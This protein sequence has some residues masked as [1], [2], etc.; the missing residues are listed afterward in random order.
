[1]T[2]RDT[3]YITYI[4]IHC[5]FL[6]IPIGHIYLEPNTTIYYVFSSRITKRSR[7]NKYRLCSV[8]NIFLSF[9]NRKFYSWYNF[10]IVEII[11]TIDRTMVFRFWTERVEERFGFMMTCASVLLYVL[12]TR[13]RPEGVFGLIVSGFWK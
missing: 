6:F 7:Y 12:C 5:I 3:V 8:G 11:V 10:I 1:M 9:K 4:I 2:I 13:F